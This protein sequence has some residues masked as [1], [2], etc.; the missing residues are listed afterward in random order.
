M[1]VGLFYYFPLATTNFPT[2][3]TPAGCPTVQFNSDPN[4]LE[5]QQTPE[6][7]GSVPQDCAHL[8]RQSQV[9]GCHLFF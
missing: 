5:L 9:P 6:G 2:G 4:C 3:W 1:C 8:K 7:K